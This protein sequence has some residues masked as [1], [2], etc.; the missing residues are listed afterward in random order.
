MHSEFG[1][2]KFLLFLWPPDGAEPSSGPYPGA[3]V[4]LLLSADILFWNPGTGSLSF[5]SAAACQPKRNFPRA[6]SASQGENATVRIAAAPSIHSTNALIRLHLLPD[7]VSGV[8]L[9]IP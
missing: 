1:G 6:M 7:S 9:S 2:T 8:S 4:C 5:L 3:C